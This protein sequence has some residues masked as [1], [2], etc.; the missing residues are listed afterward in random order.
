M[1]HRWFKFACPLL[2]AVVLFAVATR[3]HAQVKS[4]I[5]TYKQGNVLAHSFLAYPSDLSGRAPG[6]LVLPEWWGLNDYIRTRARMLARLGYVAMAVDIYGEGKNT[7]NYDRAAAWSG[8]LEAGD[9][10]ELRV[11][12]AAAL[13]ELKR[14]RHVDSSRTAAIGYCFGGATV[15]ELARSGADLLGVVSFH[16]PLNT[17]D[18]AKPGQVKAK[19]LVCQGGDDPYVRPA[20]VQAFEDEMRKAAADWE[21]NIYSG[22]QHS[23]TNPAAD[24]LHSSGLAYNKEADRRSWQAMRDFFGD[25]FPTSSTS[26]RTQSPL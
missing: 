13:Q 12:V 4:E 17:Q 14:N 1:K 22:A 24:K 8:R 2:S 21:I 18:P 3:A 25:L 15:L 6:V 16:G 20:E 7:A 19:I 9:R 5:V 10:K 23:F 11:R 26:R